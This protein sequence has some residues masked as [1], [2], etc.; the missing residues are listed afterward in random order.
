MK[1]IKLYEGFEDFEE[2]WINDSEEYIDIEDLKEGDKVIITDRLKNYIKYY[3]WGNN[4]YEFINQE[5]VVYESHYCEINNID[6]PERKI[7]CFSVRNEI[8][9]YFYVPYDC[10][11]KII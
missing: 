1:Y 4:M 5:F 2:T 10:A 3:N 8:D 11:K 9:G 6:N 7:Y